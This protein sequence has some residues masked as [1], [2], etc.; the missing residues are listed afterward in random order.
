MAICAV[1][2]FGLNE[3][4]MRGLFDFRGASAA[5]RERLGASQNTPVIVVP[6]FFEGE[7]LAEILIPPYPTC[8]FRPSYGIARPAMSSWCRECRP[9]TPK[10]I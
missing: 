3:H 2:Q 10:L 4:F 1:L 6:L 5:V 8:C 7:K 9:T